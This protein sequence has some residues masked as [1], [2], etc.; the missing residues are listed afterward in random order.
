MFCFNKAFIENK[1][2]KMICLGTLVSTVNFPGHPRVANQSIRDRQA[3]FFC[4]ALT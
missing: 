4:E 3:F 2:L 1:L